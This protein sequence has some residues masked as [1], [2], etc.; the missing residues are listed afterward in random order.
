M[1]KRYALMWSGGKDSALA[2]DRSWRAGL[3][4]G[5]L[6]SFYD[7]ATRRVRFH[8]TRVEMLEAQAAAI[9]VELQAIPTS[10]PEMEASLGREL[11]H[12]QA[13]GF[14]GVVLGDIHLADVRDWYETRVVAAGLEHVEP[15]WAEPPP[16]LLREFIA[17][18]GRA[19]LTCVELAKLDSSWLGRVTDEEF[20][21]EIENT[22]VDACGEN[23]E[24]HSFAFSG[25]VFKQPVR[26]VAGERR[27]DGGFAQLD[28]TA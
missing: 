10:W 14:A 13:E 8:A 4:I 3:D 25:P 9:G 1:T 19:V 11:A 28:L 2:L 27:L 16:T 5:R 23:G 17:S 24:Y 22:G 20:A 7:S 26:W 21:G 12:L 6:I 15:I 18:G